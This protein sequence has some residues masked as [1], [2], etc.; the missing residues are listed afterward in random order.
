MT[1]K[2]VLNILVMTTAC[3]MALWFTKSLP[4]ASPFGCDPFGYLRQAN[5][6]EKNGLKDGLSTEIKTLDSSLL[7]NIAAQI[8]DD[9]TSWS[10]MIAP[11]CH[12]Y[13]TTS[14]KI[15]TQYPPGTGYVLSLMPK[16]KELQALTVL[17]VLSIL[18]LYVA[19]NVA[20]LSFTYYLISTISFY[21][22]ISSVLK[23]QTVSYS[24]PVTVLLLT[25]ITGLLFLIKFEIKLKNI[26]V[27]FAIGALS[28]LLVNVRIASLMLLP[29]ILFMMYVDQY[30]YRPNKRLA[31]LSTIGCLG[32]LV[33]ISPLLIA[34]K[35][36][37]GGYF[38][39]TYGVSDTQF[40]LDGLLFFKNLNYYLFEN[41]SSLFLV[42]TIAVIVFQTLRAKD[43]VKQTGLIVFLIV[44]I[45]FFCIKPIA[46]DYYLLPVIFFCFSC[47]MILF[48]KN[49]AIKNNF[50]NSNIEKATLIIF[51][52]ALGFIFYAEKIK[53]TSIVDTG[54]KAPAI[55]LDK[56]AIV[57][58]D[59][60]GGVLYS[61]LGKY[62]AK[63]VFGN[64]CMQEQLIGQVKLAG[65]E[66]F[67]IEDSQAMNS[68]LRGLGLQNFEKIGIFESPFFKYDVWKLIGIESRP[69]L[70]CSNKKATLGNFKINPEIASNIGLSVTGSIQG[71]QYIGRVLITNESSQSFETFSVKGPIRLSWRFV[72]EQNQR[73][74]PGWEER[75]NINM[76]ILPGEAEVVPVIFDLPIEKGR[77]KLEVSLVQDGVAWFHHLGMKV[78]QVIVDVP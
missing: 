70:K 37:A 64:F 77:Y 27:I 56:N 30:S 47:G 42:F 2:I 32:L 67:F 24:I 4:F 21:I 35:I 63:I 19:T 76:K 34:N 31:L 7:T 59:D 1:K 51:C 13:D 69:I 20:V 75:A 36:N 38:K 18:L 28:G 26:L 22:A 60:S 25:C 11:H 68:L 3:L 48:A 61:S 10:E 8:N 55:L 71:N 53:N 6:F 57:Y 52:L 72:C 78:P 23:F 41:A 73:V 62:S 15:I 74:E 49:I 16:G 58:A 9:A 17:V 45:L 44:N 39:S 50:Q 29:M 40:V 46:I 43:S 54:A 65:N 66:Q 33:S 14:Q 5:L 12:H